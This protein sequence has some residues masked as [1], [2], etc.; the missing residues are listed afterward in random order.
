MVPALAVP[1]LGG[2]GG[3][4]GK[5]G[6]L[7]YVCLSVCLSVRGKKT[8]HTCIMLKAQCH[9]YQK[10][11]NECRQA[12]TMSTRARKAKCRQAR[13][14][15][16]TCEKGKVQTGAH[17]ANTCEKGTVQAGAHHINTKTAG[18]Q[19]VPLYT[20]P[21]CVGEKVRADYKLMVMPTS[22]V[23]FHSFQARF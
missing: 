21:K 15:P 1:Y 6:T 5:G 7:M 4:G 18:I 12:R 3:L 10:L 9:M 8:L 14:M 16:S 11:K 19:G 17:H 22:S 13:T 23:V 2:L 20:L